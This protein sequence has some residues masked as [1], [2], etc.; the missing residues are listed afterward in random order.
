MI[1]NDHMLFI[2]MFVIVGFAVF[3]AMTPG[4]VAICFSIA[5]I[6]PLGMAILNINILIQIIVYI[7]ILALC[8]YYLIPVLRRIAKIKVDPD[9]Q[10]VKTNLDL[11]IGTYGEA[12][13]DISFLNDGLVKADGKEWTAKVEEEKLEIKKGD[14]VKIK[15]I[16]GSKIIVE[17]GEQ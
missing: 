3:E 15:A 7:I 5:A 11:V 10:H 13:S 4:M 9:D 6:I 12:L 2:W 17:K 8:L 14:R 1:S 16:A